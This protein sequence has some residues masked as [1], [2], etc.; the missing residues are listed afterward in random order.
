M[1]DQSA[2]SPATPNSAG[3]ALPVIAT[4][5]VALL[6][7]AGV[8][9]VLQP[10]L[11]GDDDETETVASESPEG[12]A[13]DFVTDEA[14]VPAT[15]APETT[16]APTTTEALAVP[17]TRYANPTR[18]FTVAIPDE[19]T[20][21]SS[22]AADPSSSSV[23]AA[24]EPDATVENRNV[25]ERFLSVRHLPAPSSTVD[26]VIAGVAAA[27]SSRVELC[28]P[29]SVEPFSTG[30]WSG[31]AARFT[32]CPGLGGLLLAA[33][34]A[35]DGGLL[36]ITGSIGSP[37]DEAAL[38]AMVESIVSGP[39]EAAPV[40]DD[41]FC[42]AIPP[43]EDPASPLKIR[44]V[45]NSGVDVSAFYVFEGTETP[46]FDDANVVGPAAWNEATA[47][48][49]TTLRVRVGSDVVE[50]PFGPEPTKCVVVGSPG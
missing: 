13:E 42:F 10:V 9:W 28:G 15:V 29:A 27:D 18:T 39:D 2:P 38:V 23:E 35:P 49:G 25:L 50:V 11:F 3:G 30:E 14:V 19:L 44:F 20:A 6:I 12:V 46:V 21:Q 36:T 43:A 33:V 37:A 34:P 24:A 31:T 41:E 26:E 22:V 40:P 1:T 8:G 32:A 7:G 16:A 48:E 5:L 45:N 4:G 17:A 47:T